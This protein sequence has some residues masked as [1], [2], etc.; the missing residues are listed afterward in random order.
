MDRYYISEQYR[1]DLC[2]WI[3]G[4]FIKT[5]DLSYICFGLSN[6]HRGHISF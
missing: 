3:L 2:N 4:F 1:I 6:F 5:K